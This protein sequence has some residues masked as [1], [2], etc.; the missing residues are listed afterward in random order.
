MKQF[1]IIVSI[2][3]VFCGSL[4]FL[5]SCKEPAEEVHVHE[6]GSW[7]VLNE[8]T[9]I[10]D[11]L[12]GRDCKNCPEFERENIE[13][14]GHDYVETKNIVEA[15]CLND[16]IK[17][18]VCKHCKDIK[19]ENIKALGHAFYEGICARCEELESEIPTYIIRYELNGGQLYTTEAT[20]EKNTIVNLPNP[21]KENYIFEGW[22]TT[23]DFKKDTIVKKSIKL[24]NNITLY[25]KW[26]VAGY[27]ITLD[28]KEGFVENKEVVLKEN[29]RFALEVPTTDKYVFFAGWYLGE[30]RITDELGNGLKTWSI[31]DD[32]TLVAKYEDSKKIEHI[33]FMYEGEYPQRV[34]TNEYLIEELSK[35][36]EINKRGYLEYNGR[37]YAKLTYT[38]KNSVAKFNNGMLLE[39][40]KTYYFLVEPILWRIID[41]INDFAITEKIIDTF[42]YYESIKEHEKGEDIYPNNYDLSDVCS[43]LNADFKHLN[44]GF[45]KKAFADPINVLVLKKDIDN[46]GKT[47]QDENNK[48]ICEATTAHLFLLSYKELETLDIRLNRTSYVTDYAIARGVNVDNYTMNGEW[49]LR[50]PSAIAENQAL[51]MSTQGQ[52][53]ESL[54]D[55]SNI[56]IRPV[57][58]FKNIDE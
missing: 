8:A 7:I 35:I 46:S 48:Y 14:I 32:V 42:A 51:A 1:K 19:T 43:W 54:V 39:K 38:G 22:Y 40:N 29:V 41:E 12:R 53:F 49:W 44:E 37:Q 24:D 6:F 50:T 31:K 30:E 20:F 47:T 16:G 28:P 25:A 36:T 9:C 17:L 10:A 56:G 15:T 4:L 21:T 33:R 57:A 23:E 45:I 58:Q 26:D 13:K 11:G 18:Y 27:V 5:T 55:N 3:I 52:V 34:I 2:I